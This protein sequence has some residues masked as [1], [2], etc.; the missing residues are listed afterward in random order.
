MISAP[1]V[2]AVP[3][4]LGMQKQGDEQRHEAE[5]TG[6]GHT[7]NRPALSNC[8][9]NR[10]RK[11]E[12][13]PMSLRQGAIASEQAINRLSGYRWE[14]P[15]NRELT[16]KYRQEP[17]SEAIGAIDRS[18]AQFNEAY[19]EDLVSWSGRRWGVRRW[20]LPLKKIRRLSCALPRNRLRSGRQPERSRPISAISRSRIRCVI[21]SWRLP[22]SRACFGIEDKNSLDLFRGIS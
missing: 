13:S 9:G 11:D 19:L 12:R 2:I 5:R 18:R 8:Y 14:F 21:R 16:G 20:R 17:P 1:S 15:Q 7:S 3:P 4:I 10:S 22:A 6:G